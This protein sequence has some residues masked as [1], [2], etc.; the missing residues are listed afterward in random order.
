MSD[1]LPLRGKP[2]NL[3]EDSLPFLIQSTTGLENHRGKIV[4]RM[5]KG[6]SIA[7]NFLMLS[8]RFARFELTE[9]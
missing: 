4:I 2:N 5:N 8:I 3:F 9:M 1:P 7:I 6:I